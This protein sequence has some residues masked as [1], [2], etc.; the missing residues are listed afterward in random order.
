MKTRIAT[1]QLATVLLFATLEAGCTLGPASRSEI[2]S[3]DFGPPVTASDSKPRLTQVLFVQD[4]GAPAWMDT[5]SIYYRLTFGNAS[6]PQAYANH[7]W[8]MPPAALLTNRLRQR[9]AAASRAGI[10]VPG[11]ALRAGF[12]LRVEIDEFM[13]VFDAPDRSHALVAIRAS[14]IGNR[15]LIAQQAFSVQKE[16]MTPDA[17]GGARALR[18][19]SEDAIEQVL[20]WVSVNSRG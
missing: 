3:Y 17:E 1:L 6:R 9:L 11:D 5:P 4:V 20:D 8:V 7:R 10:I 13:Q 15:S 14:L 12:T 16:A 18:A 2:A 19:A